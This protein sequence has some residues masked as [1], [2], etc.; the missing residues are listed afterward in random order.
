MKPVGKPFCSF[1]VPVAATI[2]DTEGEPRMD[3]AGERIRLFEPSAMNPLVSSR[4]PLKERDE[5]RVI[6]LLFA[7]SSVRLAL[8][9]MVPFTVIDWGTNPDRVTVLAEAGEK[10]RIAPGCTRM[11]PSIWCKPDAGPVMLKLNVPLVMVRLSIETGLVPEG[12][13]V[14]PVASISKLA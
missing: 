10:F 13:R 11:L 12:L 8:V 7:I 9:F 14:M 2:A 6:P 3:D 1:P 4:F 5:L